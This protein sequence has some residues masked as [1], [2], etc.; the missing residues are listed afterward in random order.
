M[1]VNHRYK[2]IFLKTRKTAGTS[3]EIALS[4]FCDADDIITPITRDD[5]A[6][7]REMGFQG[8]ANHHIPLRR[9]GVADVVNTIRS[10]KRKQFY[11]HAPAAYVRDNLDPKVWAGYYKF[12]FERNPFDK[13]ISQYYWSTRQLDPP[14]SIETF[15]RDSDEQRLTNWPIYAIGD[16]IAVDFLGRFENLREDFAAVC[17]HLGLPDSVELPRA[18]AATRTDRKHYSDVLSP[19]GRARIEQVCGREIEALAYHWAVPNPQQ[20]A[21]SET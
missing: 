11:N 15:L 1:I 13:A 8:P 19:T 18:K 6:R 20:N 9:Y 21:V 14:P 17:K 4:Q 7:R 12:A 10:Q 2:F 16:Q 3:I 5:E